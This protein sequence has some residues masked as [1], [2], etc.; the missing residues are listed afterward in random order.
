[1]G[2][3]QEVAIKTTYFLGM[4]LRNSPRKS[5]RQSKIFVTD[6][7]ILNPVSNSWLRLW[8]L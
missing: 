8:F 5:S 6:R 3:V 1:M 4:N 2:V 7:E